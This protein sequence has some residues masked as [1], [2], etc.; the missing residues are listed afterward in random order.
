MLVR[1]LVAMLSVAALGA[2]SAAPT[3]AIT[4]GQPDG[5]NH[6]FVGLAADANGF[7]SGT[8]LSPT[9]FL[10]AAHCFAANESVTVVIDPSGVWANPAEVVGIVHNDPQFCLACGNGLPNADTHDLAVVV[11]Q[12]P[13]T[14]DAYGLLPKPGLVDTLPPQPSVTLVGYGIQGYS[15]QGHGGPQ[16]VDD[17]Q[18]TFAPT[19]LVPNSSVLSASFITLMAN[20]GN[21]Q[22]GVCFGDSGGPDILGNSR[23][24]VALNSLVANNAR[25]SGVS[26]SYRI[27]TPNALSFIG[28]FLG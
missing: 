11:L 19:R 13:I 28:T 6:P 15:R 9:V 27:D 16:V 12:N 22:G 26:Y 5:G 3:F 7:C 21:G 4:S 17:F 1:T 25:C 10:T 23:T 24:V 18:R 8:L 20:P 2:F 14:L